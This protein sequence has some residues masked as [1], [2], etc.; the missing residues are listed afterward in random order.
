[1]NRLIVTGIALVCLQACI[2]ARQFDELKARKERCEEE[3][4]TLKAQNLE[5]TT[6]IKELSEMTK[7]Q[8]KRIEHLQN[9]TSSMGIATRRMQALYNELHRSYDQLVE[10]NEKLMASSSAETKKLITQLQSTQEDLLSQE[11]RLKQMERDLNEREKNLNMLTGELTERQKR[12]A[13]LEEILKKK[14]S[15]VVALKNKVSDALLGFEGQGLTVQMKNG[16]VYVSLDEQLLFATG[17]T[18]IDKKGEQALKKLSKVLEQNTDINVLVEGHTDN[19][20]IKGGPIKDN[21]DLSVMRATAVVRVL[22]EASAINPVRLTPAGKGE[23]M[24]VDPGN[25]TEAR[26]KNRRTEIILTPKID[27]LLKVIETN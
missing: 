13:E 16:K 15:V 11:T 3:N 27:E 14:D 23:Y 6:K 12:V 24:P 5:L 9:D 17:S 20:P 8:A 1:M 18:V 10:N 21:W 22:T 25:S 26:K 19:V 4:S 2:P 7:D